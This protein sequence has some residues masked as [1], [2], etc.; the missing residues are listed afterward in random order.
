MIINRFITFSQANVNVFFVGLLIIHRHLSN[1]V[2]QSINKRALMVTYSIKDLEKFSGIKAH[3]IRVW[4]QRY[5]LLNPERTDSN[6]RFYDE[7]QLKHLLNISLLANNGHKISKIAKYSSDEFNQE[8]RSIYE[9]FENEASSEAVKVK[10]NGLIIAMLELDELKFEKIF[11]TSLLKRGFEGTI[12]ELIY[13]FLQRIGIMWRTGEVSCAQEHFITNLIRQKVLVAI[14]AIPLATG[15]NEKFL[16]FL[17]ESE[18]N[19]LLTLLSTY[20]LKSKG[21][22]CIYLGQDIPFQDLKSVA[23]ITS[24]HALMTFL[25]EPVSQ[26]ESQEYIN[27]LA[28]TF[29][30]ESVIIS[31]NVSF[32]HDL[33]RPG[34]VTIIDSLRHLVEVIH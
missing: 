12:L 28:D 31:G 1:V 17:P 11:S 34:N 2:E 24:P 18:F 3:T 26:E 8:V 10:I 23:E 9:R 32:L 14:D 25:T 22:Q 5:G 27:Q 30:S 20:I 4:E 6:I 21:K 7:E 33:D 29:P 16:L 15:D 19:E 13:P